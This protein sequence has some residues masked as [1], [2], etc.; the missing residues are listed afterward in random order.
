MIA[1]CMFPLHR[2]TLLQH[3]MVYSYAWTLSS[4]GCQW[5]N[6]N[7]THIKLNWTT[8]KQVS[9][10]TFSFELFDVRIQINQ[11]KSVRNLEI[12][13]GK[14]VTFHSHISAISSLIFY[15]HDLQ[16]ICNYLDLDKA[17]LL[18]NFLVS[19]CLT[20]YSSVLSGIADTDLTKLQRVLD[21]LAH[22]VTQ[23]AP[24]TYNAPLLCSLHFSPIKFWFYF[25][26]CFADLQKFILKDNPFFHSMLAPSLQSWSLWSKEGIILSVPRVKTN[27]GPRAYQSCTPALWN[28]LPLRINSATSIATY[29]IRLKTHPFDLA[30]PIWTPVYPMAHWFYGTTLWLWCWTVIQLSCHWSRLAGDIGATEFVHFIDWLIA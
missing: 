28:N 16:C 8:P 19:S 7:W 12:I 13:F 5:I 9:L 30:F 20:Y 4:L 15:I 25:K 27:A 29:R 18:V 17:K 26:I 1:S 10:P 24:I 22:V 2:R 14:N 3:C 11:T 6:W 23:S 21:W